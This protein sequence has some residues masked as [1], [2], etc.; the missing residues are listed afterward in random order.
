[1]PYF[2]R[3]KGKR[4]AAALDEGEEEGAPDENHTGTVSAIS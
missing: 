2:L 3:S 4:K 1:M